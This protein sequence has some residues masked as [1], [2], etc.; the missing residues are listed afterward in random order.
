M[1]DDKKLTNEPTENTDKLD[2]SNV[3]DNLEIKDIEDVKDIEDIEDIEDIKDIEDVEENKETIIPQ[4]KIKE[5]I[6]S[7]A[8]NV[9]TTE[10]KESTKILKKTQNKIKTTIKQKSTETYNSMLNKFEKLSDKKR[11][12]IIGGTGLILGAFIFSPSSDNAIKIKTY[13]DIVEQA[14]DLLEITE[15]LDKENK[16]LKVKLD[17][18]APWFELSEKQKNEQILIQAKEDN[19]KYLNIIESGKLYYNMTPE[20]RL[21]ADEWI[22]SKYNSSIN[23]LKEAYKDNYEAIKKD[24]ESSLAKIKEEAKQAEEA[25]K[26]AEEEAKQKAE[27]EKYNTGLTWEQIAREG[28]IGTLCKFEGKVIQV[29]KG[30]GYVQCRVATKGN[31]DN[32][33]LI[34]VVNPEK[35]ILEDDHISFKGASLGTIE[36]TTV[37]GAQMSVPAVLVA[38]YTLS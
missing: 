1:N 35:T 36:Y 28:K 16:E 31:Y 38:E 15:S 10:N 14:R 29:I 20:E 6:N 12:L 24:R 17:E 22:D 5:T 18:A 27:A 30:D 33:M 7:P 11:Y 25:K 4:E 37:L 8:T 23:L 2:N 34:Q 13:D 26:K 32:V 3:D 21:I 19:A 9:I